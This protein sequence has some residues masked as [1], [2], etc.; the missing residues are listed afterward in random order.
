VSPSVEEVDISNS[1]S[2]T[3]KEPGIA[4]G[5]PV[6]TIEGTGLGNVLRA[7]SG[8]IDVGAPDQDGYRLDMEEVRRVGS[9]AICV[10]MEI[11]MLEMRRLSAADPNG[12]IADPNARR[13][14]TGSATPFGRPRRAALM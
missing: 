6:V 11:E 12:D 7:D 4:I 10:P 1:N 8:S 13:E 2:R 14:I 9:K 5:T 3:A